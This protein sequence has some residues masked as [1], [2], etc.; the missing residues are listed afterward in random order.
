MAVNGRINGDHRKEQQIVEL[1]DVVVAIHSFVADDAAVVPEL[2]DE[3]V[4]VHW[5]SS[6]RYDA[7]HKEN[8]EKQH[9]ASRDHARVQALR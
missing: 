2:L 4:R 3:G 8:A 6:I 1:L 7:F 5:L 9:C